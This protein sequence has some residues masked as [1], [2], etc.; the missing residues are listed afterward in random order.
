[1]DILTIIFLLLAGTFVALLATVL[2]MSPI[3]YKK[4]RDSRLAR[5]NQIKEENLIGDNDYNDLK[6]RL[7]S[8]S[9][10][11][12]DFDSKL[13]SCIELNKRWHYILDKYGYEIAQKIIDHKYWIG[14]TKEQ[15]IDAKGEPTKIETEQLKTKTKETFIYGYKSSGD[16][17]V[18]EN[19]FATKIV[20]R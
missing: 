16:Y 5:L 15:L 11:F 10:S 3:Q 8:K 7:M 20:D 12:I 18:F 6:N 13:N 19:G 9:I 4:N 2:I 17:F 14:M 1:M